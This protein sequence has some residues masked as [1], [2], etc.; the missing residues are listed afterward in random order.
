MKTCKNFCNKYIKK[1]NKEGIKARKEMKNLLK[2][3]RKKLK[4]A[5]VKEKP[6]I[7]QGIE[8]INNTF[9]EIKKNKH[10]NKRAYQNAC[11][12]GFC[13]PGCKGTIFENDPKLVD[14]FY[15]KTN[16]DYLRKEGATSGCLVSSF[17]L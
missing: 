15:I 2:M 14:N 1:M 6:M 8:Q 7:L 5:T 13:N 11:T 4:T 10:K 12:K 9:K 16:T 17:Y 3:S